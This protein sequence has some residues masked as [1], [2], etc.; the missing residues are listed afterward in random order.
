MSGASRGFIRIGYQVTPDRR[1]EHDDG[2]SVQPG[3]PH[4]AEL[5]VHHDHRL[6]M[7]FALAG[8]RIDG[9]ELDDPTVVTKS[10]PAFWSMLEQL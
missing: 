2:I 5:Q 6:A 10:W 4:A 9:I 1:N 3:V 7:A 8:L